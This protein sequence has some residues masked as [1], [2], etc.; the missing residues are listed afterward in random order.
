MVKKVVEYEE[1]TVVR[2]EGYFGTSC[3]FGKCAHVQVTCSHPG[4]G[5]HRVSRNRVVLCAKCNGQYSIR[6]ERGNEE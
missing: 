1:G 4:A 2:R 3:P 5:D 6:R